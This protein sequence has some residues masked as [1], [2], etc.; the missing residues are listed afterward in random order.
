MKKTTNILFLILA[1]S[2]HSFSCSNHQK[3][4]IDL[5]NLSSSYFSEEEFKSSVTGYTGSNHSDLELNP[6]SCFHIF[7]QNPD[8]DFPTEFSGK[9]KLTGT[10]ITLSDTAQNKNSPVVLSVNENGSLT[11]KYFDHNFAFNKCKK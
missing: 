6:D 8:S 7:I 3:N 10:K 2:G 5:T 11:G 4:I 1:F 9:W